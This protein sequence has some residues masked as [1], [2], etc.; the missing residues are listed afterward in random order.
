VVGFRIG[1]QAV[2]NNR[3]PVAEGFEALPH[4]DLLG[5]VEVIKP[6]G[7]DGGD[8]LG[9]TVFEGVEDHIEPT[10]RVTRRCCGVP[11]FHTSIVFEDAFE[12]KR[13]SQ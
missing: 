9:E 6:A 10:A 5:A 7:F 4:R 13:F 2:I 11:E 3:Q 12:D 1:D 8:Q